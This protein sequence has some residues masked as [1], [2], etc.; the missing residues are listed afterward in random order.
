VPFALGTDTAGSARVPAGFNNIIGLKPTRGALSTRGVVPACRSLDCVSILALT[1][2]DSE[3]VL[4][5]AEGLDMQDAYSRARPEYESRKTTRGILPPHP[6]LAICSRP[7]WFGCS[8]HATA[9]TM[10]L[11]KARRL[12]V[13][14]EHVN[15]EPLFT[16]GSLLYDGP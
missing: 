9:Y 10:A 4:H 5:L 7:E 11:A 1:L 15:F 12:G 16:L 3:L 13:I 14:L 6:V 8:K 2:E